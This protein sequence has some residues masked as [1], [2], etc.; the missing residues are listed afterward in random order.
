MLLTSV[1]AMLAADPIAFS[2]NSDSSTEN[3][4]S[5]YRI[6]LATGSQELVAK[7]SPTKFDVEGLALD[8]KETLYAFDDESRTLFTL[9]KQNATADTLNQVTLYTLPIGGSNDVGMTFA[10][11]GTLYL[12][13]V[14]E[15]ALYRVNPSSGDME[16]I[17]SL[18]VNISG[19]AAYGSP[20]RLYGLGNGLK[21]DESIDSP[22][23]YEIN[24]STGAAKS[25]GPL[26]ALVEPY[27]QGGL[28]FDGSGQL[29]AITDRRLPN[30][31]GS[32]VLKINRDSGAATEGK[33]LTEIGFES[34]AV[35]APA[36]CESSIDPPP[37]PPQQGSVHTAG[38]PAMNPFGLAI[39]SILLL[40]T[41]LVAVRRF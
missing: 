4:D 19:I 18:G 15:N 6:D 17:G 31:Q 11:D 36:G 12:T 37:P 41:G 30:N 7:L 8:A 13:S 22:F 32:Q 1:S 40:L 33:T 27:A 25:I 35:A 14:I 29:W 9:N 10:C 28:D 34:L 23:L 20:T 39:A 26:G 2:V 38:V 3:E 24:T 5:L 16:L 21:A